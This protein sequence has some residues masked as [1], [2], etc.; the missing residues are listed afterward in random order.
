VKRAPRFLAGPGILDTTLV[1]AGLDLFCKR[2]AEGVI[3]IALPDAAGGIGIAIKIDDGAIRGYQQPVLRVLE[4]LGR[5]KDDLA[6]HLSEEQNGLLCNS[7]GELVGR[8]EAS[9]TLLDRLA[10]QH[11]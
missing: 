1:E 2:G 4:W 11:A 10:E 8:I 7:R 5:S 6:A 3:A 9:P